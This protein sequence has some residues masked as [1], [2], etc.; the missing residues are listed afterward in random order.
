MTKFE[1]IHM[2]TYSIQSYYTTF[3]PPNMYL[4]APNTMHQHIHSSKPK[5]NGKL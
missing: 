3:M 1:Y 5:F 4:C 2:H